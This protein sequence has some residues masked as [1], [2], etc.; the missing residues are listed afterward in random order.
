[1]NDT[2]GHFYVS[3]VLMY[4]IGVYFNVNMAAYKGNEQL[5]VNETIL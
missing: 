3:Y 5:G 1:M 2:N 4:I